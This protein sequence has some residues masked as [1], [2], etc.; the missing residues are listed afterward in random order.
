V[1]NDLGSSFIIVFVTT[2]SKQEAEKISLNLLE[3]KLV[4][5]ANIIDPVESHFWWSGKIDCANEFLIILKSRMDLFEALSKRIKA[6][7][8]YEIPEILALP[9]VFGSKD[10]L[11]WIDDSLKKSS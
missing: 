8:S 1:A 9:I 3:E 5:C 6:L 10:Y 2:G 11:D 4:A 7:H